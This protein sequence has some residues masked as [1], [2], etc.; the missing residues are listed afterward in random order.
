VFELGRREQPDALLPLVLRLKYETDPGVRVWVADALIHRGC[1]AGVAVLLAALRVPATQEL[2]GQRAIEVLRA[3]GDELDEAPT[4]DALEAALRIHGAHWRDTGTLRGRAL[5]DDAT[6]RAR[7]AALLAALQGFQLRPVDDAR[8]VL[9]RTGT[10]ALPLLRQAVA[11]SE[12]FL[13]THALEVLRDLGPAASSLAPDVLPLLADA[14]TRTDAARALGAMRATQAVPHLL[15]W[16][17]SSDLELR[18]AAAWA[19]GP[20]GDPRAL[21]P[22]H[23]RMDD[24]NEALDLRVM[25]AAS[26]AL[27]ELDRPAYRFLHELR[28]KKGYHEPT[29]DELIDRVDRWG[30]PARQ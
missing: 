29:L 9:S 18:T 5:A 11:A 23:A 15:A 6:T 7:L 19:L 26:V 2:A 17:S 1:G 16:L 14:L 8:F 25:A 24:A 21:A 27:F 20:I 28:A 22:L 13:R 3:L 10:L 30:A 4:W 12:P